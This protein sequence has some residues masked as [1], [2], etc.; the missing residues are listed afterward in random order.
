MCQLRYILLS[1]AMGERHD[2]VSKGADGDG[3]EMQLCV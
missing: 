1:L 2:Q 3:H